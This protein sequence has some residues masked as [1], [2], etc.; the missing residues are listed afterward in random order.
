MTDLPLTGDP[1][2]ASVWRA[3]APGASGQTPPPAP[4]DRWKADLSVVTAGYFPAMGIRFVRGRNF[5]DADR[6]SEEQLN[7]V[8]SEKQLNHVETPRPGVAVINAAFAS[9]YFPNEDPIG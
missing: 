5:T 6:F 9:R 1:F 3:D 2:T 7:D 8:F 4:R